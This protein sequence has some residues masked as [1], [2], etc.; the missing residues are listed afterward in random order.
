MG[1]I[2]FSL[3]Q[4]QA[5]TDADIYVELQWWLHPRALAVSYSWDGLQ[6]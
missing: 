2:A 4:A 6:T 3:S 5:D 1:L